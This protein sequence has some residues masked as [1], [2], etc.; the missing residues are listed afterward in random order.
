VN[1]IWLRRILFLSDKACTV[2]SGFDIWRSVLTLLLLEISL[3]FR[4]VRHNENRLVM[5]IYMTFSDI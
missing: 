2:R 1:P 5:L 4:M 3:R